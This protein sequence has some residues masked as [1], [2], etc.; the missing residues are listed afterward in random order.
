MGRA[1][2][3]EPGRGTDLHHPGQP[4]R[5]PRPNDPRL[6]SLYLREKA[7]TVRWQPVSPTLMR[8]LPTHTT[9]RGATDPDGPLLRYA[10][11]KPI[12]Y[13][14]YDHLWTSASTCIGRGRPVGT[15]LSTRGEAVTA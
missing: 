7:E 13:L 4:L 2:W 6:G 9:T 11:G 1:Q 3:K 15:H 12:T 5:T 10:T 8:H 14:R